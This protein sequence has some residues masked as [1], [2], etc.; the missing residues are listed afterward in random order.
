MLAGRNQPSNY[1]RILED[2]QK[3]IGIAS[4]LSSG[5]QG[6]RLAEMMGL[7]VEKWVQGAASGRGSRAGFEAAHPLEIARQDVPPRHS[8]DTG[9]FKARVAL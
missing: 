1:G 6:L 4:P 3:Q 7:M 8:P 2:A 9:D 5:Q